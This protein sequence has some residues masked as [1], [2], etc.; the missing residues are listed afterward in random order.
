MKKSLVLLACVLAIGVASAQENKA[1]NFEF[2]CNI[3]MTTFNNYSAL[4]LFADATDHYSTWDAAFHLGYNVGHSMI[5]LEY[6]AAYFNTSAIALNETANLNR[7]SLLGRHYVGIGGHWESFVGLRMGLNILSNSFT[8]LAQD[9]SRT[10]LGLS[11]M[12]EIGL[13]YCLDNGSYLGV[14]AGFNI[15]GSNL[16]KDV[17]LPAGLVPND[18]SMLGGYSLM[19]QYGIRF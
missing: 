11:T 12:F 7:I 10:R 13:N 4:S 17:E 3:G 2:G 15:L 1:K 8:Y 16:G 19:M 5:G 9:Y 6:Q 18:K 14:S